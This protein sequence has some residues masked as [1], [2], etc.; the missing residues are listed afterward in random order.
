MYSD[1]VVVD[2]HGRL[3]LTPWLFTLGIFTPAIRKKKEA[4]R[5]LGFMPS[6]KT[7]MTF[8]QD[9]PSPGNVQ[10]NYHRFIQVILESLEDIQESGGLDF[11]IPYGGA[12]HKVRLIFVIAFVI[13]DTEEHDK[14]CAHFTCRTR[15]IQNICRVCDCP[16]NE[17]NNEDHQSTRYTK[18]MYTA[19]SRRG[20]TEWFK[21]HSSHNVPNAFYK[22]DMGTNP[23]NIHGASPGEILHMIQIGLLPYII[24]G[25]YNFIG[26]NDEVERC[27]NKLSSLLSID[28]LA[29]QYGCLLHRQSETDHPRTKFN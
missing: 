6:I 15:N 17:T 13:G 1:G 14:M 20:D 28:L 9:R 26:N 22:L 24:D 25:F 10:R 29:L 19:A 4:W 5:H 12:I 2:N 21:R 3:P 16:T 8:H 7:E 18:A 11:E 23:F 27:S